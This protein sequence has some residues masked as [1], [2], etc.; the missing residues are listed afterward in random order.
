MTGAADSSSQ[1]TRRAS[2]PYCDRV[3]RY[4]AP[5]D[6]F[7]T[8][9][10]LWFESMSMMWIAMAV[11][12]AIAATLVFVARLRQRAQERVP[13]YRRTGAQQSQRGARR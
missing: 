8:D 2:L 12:V 10:S 4:V 5:L 9:A 11:T 13:Q 6:R 3:I 7:V 1:V